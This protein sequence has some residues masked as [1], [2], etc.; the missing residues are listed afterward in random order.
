MEDGEIESV[1]WLKLCCRLSSISSH[2]TLMAFRVS[3]TLGMPE[4]KRAVLSEHSA[5][6]TVATMGIV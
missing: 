3:L 1:E 6:E 5:Q 2:N 4:I